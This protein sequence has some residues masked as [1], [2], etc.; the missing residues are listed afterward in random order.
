VRTEAQK[1]RWL[2]E[3]DLI[4]GLFLSPT[5]ETRRYKILAEMEAALQSRRF[6]IISHL[7]KEAI[8][9]GVNLEMVSPSGKAGRDL[10]TIKGRLKKRGKTI[11]GK[12]EN[13]LGNI[14]NPP[15]IL[16]E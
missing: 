7:Q 8:R 16:G 2:G 10:A 5:L 12:A 4:E 1:A 9:E 6:D 15:E 14:I 13:I 11:R 3:R